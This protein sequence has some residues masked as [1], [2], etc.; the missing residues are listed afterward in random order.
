MYTKKKRPSKGN[1]ENEIKKDP[2]C[3][4]SNRQKLNQGTLTDDARELTSTV[5]LR[6]DS[7]FELTNAEEVSVEAEAD[8]HDSTGELVQR[9][10]DLVDR[11]DVVGCIS[12]WRPV[13]DLSGGIDEK[14]RGEMGGEEGRGVE[15]RR[16]RRRREE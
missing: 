2:S 11:R 15:D 6:G 3:C 9:M 16:R 1:N 10:Q 4:S 14:G 13:S 8:G 12:T 7:P 5:R